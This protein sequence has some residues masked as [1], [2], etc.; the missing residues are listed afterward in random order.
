MADEIFKLGA[1]DTEIM[2]ALDNV[3]AKYKEVA[4]T[5]VTSEEAI[6][7]SIRATSEEAERLAKV[8]AEF[9]KQEEAAAAR[10][11]ENAKRFAA[12]EAELANSIKDTLAALDREAKAISN[13][14]A[15]ITN[16][17]KAVQ[18][19]QTATDK[20]NAS[21]G[22]WSGTIGGLL[23]RLGKFAGV[24]G[25]VVGVMSKLESVMDFV[26][27]AMGAVSA[28]VNVLL[29]RM[30]TL[31]DSVGRLFSGDFSGAADK[32]SEAF[33]GI[34]AAIYDAA[35]AGYDLRAAMQALRDDE[36]NVAVA[37]EKRIAAAERAKA[38]AEDESRTFNARLAAINRAIAL[39]NEIGK[40]RQSFANRSLELARK[41]FDLAVKTGEEKKATTADIQALNDAEIAAI[42]Q[43][44][45]TEQV[46]I[47][48]LERRAQ[49]QK[50][51]FEFFKK[52]VE[53]AENALAKIESRTPVDPV[54]L[55][56]AKVNKDYD[57]LKKLTEEAIARLTSLN[58]ERA[59]TPE[60]IELQNQ[61]SG[62]FV[63]IEEA[64]ME[65]LIDVLIEA[66]GREL[67]L[68][69]AQKRAKEALA[70]RDFERAKKELETAR[71]LANQEIDLTEQNFATFI[72][73]LESNGT[74]KRLIEQKQFEFDNLIKEKRILAEIEFQE[75]MLKIL[76][77]GD[78]SQKAAIENQIKLLKAQLDGLFIPLKEETKK[79]GPINSIWDLLGITDRDQQAAFQQA[80]DQIKLALQELAGARIE[81]AQ[82]A[83]AAAD[84]VIES[85][86]QQLDE[87]KKLAEEGKANNVDLIKKELAEAEAVRAD[88]L[89]REEK[90]RK[91]AILL[92]SASQISGL[93]T[94]SVN[95]YKALS[96]LG[97]F[98]IAGAIGTIALMFGSF[99]K[100]KADAL[101]AV[102]V[103]KLR[104]GAKIEGKTHEQGGE[105]RELERGEQV[106]GASES[107][108]QDKFF[109]N[110]RKGRYA[111][112]DLYD[113][114][115]RSRPGA[116]RHPVDGVKER[117]EIRTNTQIAQSDGGAVMEA[118]KLIINA[119]ESRP[120][121]APWKSGYKEI[122][123][124]GK[125]LTIKSVQPD[126]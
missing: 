90:A 102:S 112:V 2:R 54:Q 117:V 48:L 28:T 86:R 65:A 87:E 56:L 24:A 27:K 10:R 80:A 110:L 15:E 39:E 81:E 60:E 89:K 105:L 58:R 57:D 19:T 41:E 13:V 69:E 99:A 16:Q 76:G 82:A 78:E 71:D 75:S 4:K 121:Y 100:A 21:S 50:E 5:A 116:S 26:D 36:L 40:T 49:I 88:A 83:V 94:A 79:S 59:L 120:N 18:S 93:L 44:S 45:Q 111:G 64:R 101:K 122:K 126:L 68:E 8:Q 51:Q 104:K 1:D 124:S 29:T 22:K 125:S 61:L 97:P 7:D 53:F 77:A 12:Q 34:G 118:A 42:E 46:R 107:S 17:A 106:V 85:K 6:Q 109:D 91:A 115:E 38:I 123:K 113:V 73:L 103:P 47:G 108:G 3:E 67:E 11:A 14:S 25:I 63:K 35:V 95:I 37:M 84:R 62:S 114:A 55:D 23:G 96:V 33:S 98:G 119:I 70:K 30:S 72:A 20:T 31:I 92:D 74:D 43:Q 66:A 52:T 32:F 9:A